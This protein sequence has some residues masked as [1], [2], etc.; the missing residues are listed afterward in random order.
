[1]SVKSF[2][3]NDLYKFT[4]MF[5]V[6]CNKA[7]ANLKVRYNFF[8]RNDVK[9]PDGFDLELKK[10]VQD[11][12]NLKL[13]KDEKSFFISKCGHYLPNW[14]FDVLEGYRYDPNEVFIYME[15]GNLKLKIEGYWWRTILWE[16]P[17]MA[18]ISELYFEMTQKTYDF[19]SNNNRQIRLQNNQ[20]KAALMVMNGLKVSDFGTRRRYSFDNQKE[21]LGDLLSYG[22]GSITGTSNVHL[23]HIFNINPHGTQAHEWYMVHSALYGYKM[24]NKVGLDN[25]VN[26]YGGELGTSLTDTFT[27]EIFFKT[28]NTLYAKLFDGV[29]H[30]SGD[31]FEY[32][33]KVVAHYKSLNIDF[34]NKM[35][36]FSDGLD[37]ELSSKILE[38][39]RKL[40]IRAAFGIGTNLSN[41]LGFKPLNMVIK[42]TQV[43][44]DGEWIDV[45]KLSDNLGK[46]TG[47]LDEIIICKKVLHIKEIVYDRQPSGNESDKPKINTI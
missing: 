45:V 8:N 41:D 14:F 30:D 32:A 1:M 15:D 36:V 17:L 46:H 5:A 9:F 18:I 10:R 11:M 21:V 43:S 39:C 12:S 37:V 31:P 22:R 27:S 35:I 29:R 28:F 20:R 38:H 13:T 33:N 16:V 40:G 3:D 4:M 7:L 42:V 44:I 23:A 2:I 47:N 34:S 6:L 24:A 26:A 19:N 25:W